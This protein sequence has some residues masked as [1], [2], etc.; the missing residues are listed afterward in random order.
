MSFGAK[1]R[2]LNRAQLR[3]AATPPSG[4]SQES[5]WHCAF[6]TQTYTDNSTTSLT[7]FQ[8]TN[9]D[10]T[11]SNMDAAGMFPAPQTFQI[12]N[13]CADF[14]TAAPV[15][16][17]AGD[18]VG[19]LNDLALL[20]LTSRATWTL[21]ISNK[22]YGPYPLT[23]L[24]GT[25]GPTGFGWGTFT[26][27]ESI[28]YARNEPSPGWNYYGRVI[29]PEQTNFNLVLNFAAA[30]N[31]TADWRIRISMLGVLARRVV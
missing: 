21:N 22:A 5:I 31:L 8:A 3:A 25:G 29:I 6:D 19:D 23:L 27:E 16:T 17:N 7:F 13:I 12:H 1:F 18:V 2:A 9:T 26:A 15:S 28:Q 10:R 11:L 30:Q 24:H 14:L 4:H 20:L